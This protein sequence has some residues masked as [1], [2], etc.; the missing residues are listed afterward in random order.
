MKSI[1]V[2][3]QISSNQDNYDYNLFDSFNILSQENYEFMSN[4]NCNFNPTN[5]NKQFLLENKDTQSA[6]DNA[7]HIENI[8]NRKENCLKEFKYNN[9]KKVI[10]PETKSKK[11]FNIIHIKRKTS[12][13][14]DTE[15][16]IC[17]K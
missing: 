4:N 15:N 13:N 14:L 11:I 10:L 3:Y 7:I 9:L 5:I 16:Q 1:W 17:L 2:R 12:I 6:L 8:L